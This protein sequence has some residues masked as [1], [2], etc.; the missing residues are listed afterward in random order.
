VA[1]ESRRFRITGTVQGV[2]FRHSTRL[3]AVRLRVAGLARNLADGSVE[4][5]AHGDSAAL[6]Q[7]RDWL[8]HGPPMARVASVEEFAH[9]PEDATAAEA[10]A[11]EAASFGIE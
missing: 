5:I 3:E 4:V 1:R 7:L 10:A 9:P 2:Y 6:G 11:A 8:H